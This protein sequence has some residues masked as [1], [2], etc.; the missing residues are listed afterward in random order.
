MIFINNFCYW[1]NFYRLKV[2]L[3]SELFF[4][5]KSGMRALKE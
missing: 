3:M 4:S 2:Y 1:F 5:S